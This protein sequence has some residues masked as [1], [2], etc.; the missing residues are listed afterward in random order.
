MPCDYSKYP[1]NWIDIRNTILK[2]ADNRCELCNAANYKPHW[3]TGSK[4]VLTIHHINFDI[5]DSR[6][7]NLI[8]LCQ[9]CHI[10]LDAGQKALKCLNK[11]N[12]GNKLI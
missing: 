12:G 2:R 4:V 3:K 11:K 9:R 7:S 6:K 8:A 1:K 10:K 5:T